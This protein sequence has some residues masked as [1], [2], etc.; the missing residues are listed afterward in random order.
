MPAL[1]KIPLGWRDPLHVAIIAVI[2]LIGIGGAFAV[3]EK[4]KRHS[5]RSCPAPCTLKTDEK[6]ATHREEVETV[7]WPNYAH[8]V[9][10]AVTL[11]RAPGVDQGEVLAM[12]AKDGKLMWRF[13]LP[14]RSE[15]SP[16]V[17]GSRVFVGSESGDIYGLNRKTGKPDWQV[18]T[19]GAVKGGPRCGGAT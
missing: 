2:S 6:P 11:Q 19:A 18:T 10:C 7:D 4:F 8:G 12:R 1:P 17:I 16:I 14:G 9:V 3:Y 5:D 15:T 13:P